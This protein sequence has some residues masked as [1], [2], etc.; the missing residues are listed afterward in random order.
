MKKS[1]GE[2]LKSYGGIVRTLGSYGDDAALASRSIDDSVR[3]NC[4]SREDQIGES[5]VWDV[6][7][8]CRPGARTTRPSPRID[9]AN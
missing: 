2:R 1:A 4:T 3:I 6:N 9:V 8:Y 7:E 5:S